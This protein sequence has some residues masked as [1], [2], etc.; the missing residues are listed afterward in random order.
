[1][2]APARSLS[3]SFE[4]IDPWALPELLR[5]VSRTAARHGVSTLTASCTLT[6]RIEVTEGES[7]LA[8][9]E[10]DLNA[11]WIYVGKGDA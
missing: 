7:G 8:A 2:S 4:E 11:R 6:V 10:R 3:L 1:M 9:F 5:I